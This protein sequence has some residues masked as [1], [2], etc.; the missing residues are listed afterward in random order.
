MSPSGEKIPKVSRGSRIAKLPVNKIA[1]ETEQQAK[2][3]FRINSDIRR[4]FNQIMSHPSAKLRIK[5]ENNAANQAFRMWTAFMRGEP[6]ASLKITG[7]SAEGKQV[8]VF[9]II[10]LS[11][12]IKKVVRVSGDQS[13]QIKPIFVSFSEQDIELVKKIASESSKFSFTQTDRAQIAD[14][15]DISFEITESKIFGA[16]KRHDYVK[17]L[18]EEF[19][20]STTSQT[21]DPT[22]A[23]AA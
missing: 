2:V 1:S 11:D 23:R 13:F 22:I 8:D 21:S 10:H 18:D 20:V 14:A 15:N 6:L 5:T 3:T 16:T 9:D 17:E 12:A 19:N 4:S 7:V